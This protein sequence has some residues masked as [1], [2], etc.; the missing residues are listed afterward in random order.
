MQ[1]STTQS[2]QTDQAKPRKKYEDV[3]I[4]ISRIGNGYQVTELAD[5]VPYAYFELGLQD[6]SRPAPD[7]MPCT[8]VA[9]HMIRFFRRLEAQLG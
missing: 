4:K 6:N 9:E 5:N 7:N 3:T 1:T 8:T 2:Q